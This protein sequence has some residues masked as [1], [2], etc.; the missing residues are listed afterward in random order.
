MNNF[1]LECFN[2]PAVM[3]ALVD[4]LI[5]AVTIWI[6]VMIGLLIGWSWRPSWAGLIS[7]GFRSKC[8][9]IWAAA[10]HCPGVRRFWVAITALLAFP[11]RRRLWFGFCGRIGKLENFSAP[12]AA[13]QLDAID[14]PRGVDVK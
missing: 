1:A 5:C 7:L 13:Q 8:R 14:D 3:E 6:A 2:K 10:S 9:F 11:F 12:A 4:I